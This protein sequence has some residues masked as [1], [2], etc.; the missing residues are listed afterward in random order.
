VAFAS[1]G[2]SVAKPDGAA[3]AWRAFYSTR[4][5]RELRKARG[6]VYSVESALEAGQTR[7]LYAV[8]YASDPAKVWRVR[9][10]GM[11]E[12]KEPQTIPAGAE[13]LRQAET[14]LLREIPRDEPM[15]ATRRYAVPGAAEVKP[16]F[17]NYLRP[18]DLVRVSQ[19]PAP[20]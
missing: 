3:R 19:G 20:Q 6:L 15:R 4:L 14:L 11:R 18:D 8:E 10:I 17:A 2:K 16:A 7:T 13:E 12:R 1:L 9:A 5:Y